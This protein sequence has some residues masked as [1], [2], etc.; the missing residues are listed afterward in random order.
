MVA[1]G[2]LCLALAVVLAIVAVTSMHWAMPA[3]AAGV[4][5]AVLGL[6]LFADATDPRR[7]P[8]PRTQHEGGGDH[9]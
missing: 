8:N 2:L 5:F 7:K 4:I 6:G 9:G 1:V 3:A